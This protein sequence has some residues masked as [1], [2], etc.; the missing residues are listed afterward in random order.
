M[1]VKGYEIKQYIT[2][3]YKDKERFTRSKTIEEDHTEEKI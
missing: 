3:K 1:K 2:F